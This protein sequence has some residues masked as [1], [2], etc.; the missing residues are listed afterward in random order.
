MFVPE[1]L[2]RVEEPDDFPRHLIEGF[3]LVGFV[4]VARAARQRSIG[5]VVRAVS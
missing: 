3:D 5:L 2:A 1:V 4:E